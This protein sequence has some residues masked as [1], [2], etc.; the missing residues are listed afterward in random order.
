MV[1]EEVETNFSCWEFDVGVADG[2]REVDG[3]WV[4]GVGGGEVDVEVPFSACLVFSKI[5]EREE[6]WNFFSSFFFFFFFRGR[7]SYLHKQFPR[8]L[9]GL[10]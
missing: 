10:R 2:R 4:G 5:G 9:K 3:G 8:A 6:S 7:E 1:R